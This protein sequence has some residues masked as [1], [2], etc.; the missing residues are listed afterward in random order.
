[1]TRRLFDDRLLAARGGLPLDEPI[2]ERPLDLGEIAR[3]AAT[4]RGRPSA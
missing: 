3:A 2:R 4:A 1:V